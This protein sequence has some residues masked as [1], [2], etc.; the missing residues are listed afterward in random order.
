MNKYAYTIF[1]KKDET[2]KRSILSFWT[3]FIACLLALFFQMLRTTPA[4]NFISPLGAH[5]EA[6]KEEN[7][8]TLAL[9][10]K[11]NS[12]GLTDLVNNSIPFSESFTDAPSYIVADYDTG[13]IYAQKNAFVSRPIASITKVMTGVVALDL[14]HPVETFEA[15]ERASREIPTRIGV[16]PGEQL[17][18]D[19]LL[20]A[21][22]LFSGNDAARVIQEGVD[23]KYG[24]E[25]F[26]SSM[27]RKAELL[28]MTNSHFDNPMGFDSRENY[29]SAS[30]IA[31][32]TRYALTEY[33]EISDIARKD[34]EFIGEN[35][36]HK[37]FRL[38]NW[39]GLI[40]V[41]PNVYGMKI[42][43]TEAAGKTTVVVSERDR[44]KIIAVILGAPSIIERDLWAADLLDY[45]F[46]KSVGL[47]RIAVTVDQ[48]KEKY[49]TWQ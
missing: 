42:G 33:P 34:Y 3:S 5:A 36:E 24:R 44:K 39:N 2:K 38:F 27:N 25:V 19:E 10:V 43:N 17:T 30:D 9:S 23:K 20:H 13:E 14:A 40:G 32:L 11:E 35:H 6:P 29:S 8:V 4:L 18:L 46:E 37:S 47:P 41:Y 21:I 22:I 49:A 15:T 1:K 7:Y 16:T 45:G 12:Y 48:L 28:G 26:I 31:I